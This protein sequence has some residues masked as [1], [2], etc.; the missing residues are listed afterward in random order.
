MYKRKLIIRTLVIDGPED[1]VDRTYDRSAYT[2]YKR[3]NQGTTAVIIKE[4]RT[5]TIVYEK[6]MDEYPPISRRTEVVEDY[7]KYAKL[8]ES[9]LP[10][11]SKT[12]E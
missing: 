5:D 2:I 9:Y 8:I 3:F 6:E 1:W 12:V 7:D 10:T 4:I 11:K